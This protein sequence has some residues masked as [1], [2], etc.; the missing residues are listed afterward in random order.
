[1]MVTAALSL[2]EAIMLRRTMKL[3]PIRLF[4][5]IT[6]AAIITTGYLLNAIYPLIAQR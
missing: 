3:Q 1:M 6:S 5:S 2:P 4:F